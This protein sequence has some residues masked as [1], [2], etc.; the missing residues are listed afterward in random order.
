[1]IRTKRLEKKLE[2]LEED[3]QVI[4]DSKVSVACFDLE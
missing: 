4:R 3:E 2:E 1:M